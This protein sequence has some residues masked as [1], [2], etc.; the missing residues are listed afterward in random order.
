MDNQPCWEV[1]DCGKGPGTPDECVVV[2]FQLADG[3]LNGEN[4]SRACFY[5]IGTSCYEDDADM[6]VPEKLKEYCMQCPF[7]LNIIQEEGRKS[8]FFYYLKYIH[9]RLESEDRLYELPMVQKSLFK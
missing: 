8:N 6:S 3:F 4:A 9:N 2:N 7:Y 1:M 5:T